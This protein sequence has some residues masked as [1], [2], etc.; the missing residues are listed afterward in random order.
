MVI[1]DLYSEESPVWSWY[2]LNDN[3]G[4]GAFGSSPYFGVDFIWNML[5]NFGGRAGLFAR[6]PAVASWPAAA[7]KTVESLPD[8]ANKRQMVGVGLTPEAIET[9]PVAYDL[10]MENTWRAGSGGEVA[11]LDTWIQGYAARR[12]S[13]SLSPAVGEAW[14]IL[15]R[16][17]YGHNV[18]C[19]I[20]K[21]GQC[22]T[23][24]EG[25]SGSVLAGRPAFAIAKVS[26]C[27]TTTL[28]YN[29]TELETGFHLLLGAADAE[30]STLGTQETYL[31]DLVTLAVQVISNR[32]LEMLPQIEAAFRNSNAVAELVTLTMAFEK[33]LTTADELL[34]TRRLFLMGRQLAAAR[35][36]GTGSALTSAGG[37]AGSGMCA[38]SAA[39]RSA[40]VLAPGAPAPTTPLICEANDCC[41]DHAPAAGEI[42]CFAI[43]VTDTQLYEWNARTQVRP[44]G[45]I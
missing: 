32:A 30:G 18:P 44:E 16:T 4:K 39:A 8:S 13:G 22:P 7:L 20:T 10:M 26:C 5:H 25:T 27:D 2:A 19:A 33:L 11:E 45:R 1:L 37:A 31:Y 38:I 21:T 23:Y 42:Q 40:C 28:Y 41:F 43:N 14:S 12:Y 9:S 3:Y 34:G 17:V 36:W 15:Q 35:K 29:A 24:K 6:L